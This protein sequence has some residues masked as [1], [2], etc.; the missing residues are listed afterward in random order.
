MHVPGPQRPVEG[1]FKRLRGYGHLTEDNIGE[2]LRE[3]RLALLEADANV[4]VVR[5]FL[6]RVRELAVGRDVLE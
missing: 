2:A 4:K 5:T 3:V 6:E 1:I